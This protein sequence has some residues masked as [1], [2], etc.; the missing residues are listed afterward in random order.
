MGGLRQPR[1]RKVARRRRHTVL[2]G[3]EHPSG[4]DVLATF[5]LQGDS[6]HPL[7]RGRDEL[8]Q[9]LKRV[10]PHPAPLWNATGGGDIG[11]GAWLGE[12]C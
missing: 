9:I 6:H 11:T 5:V 2:G 8:V 1:K 3:N 4:I 10:E 7:E 12:S